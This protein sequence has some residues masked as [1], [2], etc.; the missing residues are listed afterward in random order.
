MAKIPPPFTPSKQWANIFFTLPAD[1]SCEIKDE[2]AFPKPRTPSRASSDELRSADGP[3]PHL[4]NK[5]N[6]VIDRKKQ[7]IQHQLQKPNH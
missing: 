1:A 2:F 4:P 7:A 5:Q 6:L 3:A